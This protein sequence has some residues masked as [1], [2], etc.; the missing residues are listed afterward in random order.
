MRKLKFGKIFAV[1]TFFII[2]VVVSIL[3]VSQAKAA[4][5][6]V[7]SPNGGES[8]K[9]GETHRIT[10][11]AVGVEKVTMY[12]YDDRI[13]SSGAIVNY[14][15]LDNQPIS[16]SQGYYDWTIPTDIRWL[17]REGGDNRGDNYKIRIN[18]ASTDP[19]LDES[20]NFFN[21]LNP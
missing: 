14:P 12:L 19:V 2:V 16:A 5:I 15:V 3:S 8:W 10:W 1:M 7:L 13:T 17:P 9:V 11:A 4:S 21:I 6:T 20:D 18:D